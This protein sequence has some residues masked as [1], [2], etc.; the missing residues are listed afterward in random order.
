MKESN[1]IKIKLPKMSKFKSKSKDDSPYY[2][3][4]IWAAEHSGVDIPDEAFAINVSATWLCKKDSDELN[5]LVKDWL[6]T[7]HKLTGKALER[8]YAYHMLEISPA[9]WDNDNRPKWAFPGNAYVN[10]RQIITKDREI[11]L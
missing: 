2:L 11:R 9:S 7:K 4:H 8:N 3:F 6:K 5:K 10:E 1:F